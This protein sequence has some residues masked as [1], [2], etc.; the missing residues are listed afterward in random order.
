MVEINSSAP[1]PNNSVGGAGNQPPPSKP[2]DVGG[3]WGAYKEWLGPE[4]YKKMQ[5]MLCQSVSR[6]INKD[7]EKE[8]ET[9]EI[10]RKSIE[11]DADIYS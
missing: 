7:K 11:G 6:Q 8:Q 2:F 5:E 9:K 10:M 3:G 1:D 4:G